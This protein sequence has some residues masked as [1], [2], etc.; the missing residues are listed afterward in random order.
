MIF[1]FSLPNK[2]NWIGLKKLF[3]Q[4]I[5][6]FILNEKLQISKFAHKPKKYVEFILQNYE[7]QKNFVLFYS[8]SCIFYLSKK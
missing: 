8:R 1:E 7:C 2:A 5:G 6:F 3:K 4:K